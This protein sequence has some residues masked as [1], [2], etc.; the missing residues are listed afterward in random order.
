MLFQYRNV[1]AEQ[2][3]PFPKASD[4]IGIACG[5]IGVLA[6]KICHVRHHLTPDTLTAAPRIELD[7]LANNI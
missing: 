5:N 2:N 3:L 6:K 4:Q 1:R 7:L